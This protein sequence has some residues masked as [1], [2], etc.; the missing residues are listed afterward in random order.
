MKYPYVIQSAIAGVL[1]M[2]G[3]L[4]S[5]S[6]SSANNSFSHSKSSASSNSQF[7]IVD[8]QQQQTTI[9]SKFAKIKNQINQIDWNR[10]LIMSSFGVVIAGP[11]FTVLNLTFWI[12]ERKNELKLTFS[13]R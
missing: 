13:I 9:Q 2:A 11:L 6:I 3:D 5:Q 7:P 4:L 12:C 1:W 8:P 10:V